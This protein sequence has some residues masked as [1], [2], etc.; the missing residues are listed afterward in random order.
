[1][2]IVNGI[3][4]DFVEISQSL[5]FAVEKTPAMNTAVPELRLP[6]RFH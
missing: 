2:A 5:S 6:G 3:V 1:M 4:E